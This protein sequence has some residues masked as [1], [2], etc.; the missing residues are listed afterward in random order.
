MHCTKNHRVPSVYTLT[1][2]RSMRSIV[3][4]QVPLLAAVSLSL[5]RYART[6]E[7]GSLHRYAVFYAIA[8]PVH[9]RPRFAGAPAAIKR[10]SNKRQRARILSK[11]ERQTLAT[12]HICP[13]KADWARNENGPLISINQNSTHIYTLLRKSSITPY[14]VSLVHSEKAMQ[15]AT[16]SP[17]AHATEDI[18]IPL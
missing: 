10:R 2:V 11:G 16:G 6:K 14:F 15:E 1:W 3:L 5:P 9:A 13:H 4:G 7:L 12:E 18:H 17:S 8:A